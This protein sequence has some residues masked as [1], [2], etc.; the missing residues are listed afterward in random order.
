MNAKTMKKHIARTIL[1]RRMIGFVTVSACCLCHNLPSALAAPG[2]WA[3]MTNMPVS[4]AT[5]AGCEVDGIFYVVGGDG[6]Y[7][8]PVQL[9]T[10]F[11]YNPKTDK[12]T[13]KHDMPTAR[14][15]AAACVVNGIIYV[16]SG[17][18]VFDPV[19]GVVEAYDPKTDTWTTKT[20]LSSPRSMVTVCAVDGII[21]AIGGYNQSGD[22]VTTVEAYDPATGQWTLKK[23]LPAANGRGVAQAVDGIIYAF[24]N[25]GT[26]AYDPKTNGWTTMALIPSGSLNCAGS[27]SGVVDGIIYLF[28]GLASDDSASYSFTLA[29]D[30]VGNSFATIPLM[31]VTCQGTNCDSRRVYAACATVNGK[32]YIAGGF[33]V[34]PLVV[35]EP[36][37]IYSSTL[38]FDP[39]GG[40]L[41]A[42][43][44]WTRKAGM[45]KA[46]GVPAACAVDGI[47]YVVGGDG[48]TNAQSHDQLKTLFAYD[49]KT[50]LWTQKMDMPTPRRALAA[51]VVDGIIYVIGGGGMA[52]PVT[53]AVEAYDPKTDT[54]VAKTGLPTPRCFH[55]ACAVDGI[56]YVIGG[57][58]THYGNPVIVKTVEAYDPKTDQW[59]P[60]ADLSIAARFGGDQVVNGLIY[61]CYGKQTFAYDP[62]TDHWTNKAPIPAAWSYNSL[63]PASSV[64]DGIVYLFGGESDDGSTTYKFTLAYDPVQNNFTAKRWM[65]TNTLAA[66]AATIDGKIYIAGGANLDPDVYATIAVYSNLWVFDPQGGV[67]PQISSLTLENTNQVRLAWQGEAGR[68]YG[69]ESRLD[70]AKGSW[71]R[72]ILSSGTTTILATNASVEAT[73]NVSTTSPQRFFRVLEAN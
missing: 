17:G 9:Q 60:K 52:D 56:I 73:C 33:N 50:D 71:T 19:V 57:I 27:A 21:Y 1:S 40:V 58:E 11:A 54:W 51:A 20:N 45:P 66:A 13:Q 65:R 64:V 7:P 8:N 42:P 63:G 36:L 28:G 69:V 37:I 2:S 10:M 44:S 34:D 46:M 26:F 59:T 70:L 39:H 4:K 47:L 49:P 62:Q 16:I 32:I 48:G 38:V 29:Y 30:P 53:G 5:A 23:N 67:T 12:W 25:R 3:Q 68:L 72:L 43:G 35:S 41:A 55:N 14:R 18:G 6:T 31:P 22:Q 15:L 24:F 61:A